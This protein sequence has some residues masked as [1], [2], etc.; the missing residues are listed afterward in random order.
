[1]TD[2]NQS[3]DAERFVREPYA[4]AARAGYHVESPST[5]WSYKR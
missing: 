4:I 2:K 3:F 5:K 1:M